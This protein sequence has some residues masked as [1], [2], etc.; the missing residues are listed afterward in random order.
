MLKTRE[1]HQLKSRSQRSFELT[2]QWNLQEVVS[3]LLHES[4][5]LRE[6]GQGPAIVEVAL[7]HWGMEVVVNKVGGC[8]HTQIPAKCLEQQKL[9]FDQIPLVE[10]NV[11]AAH[12]AQRIQLLQFGD[13]VLLLLK[14]TCK[15]T[16]RVVLKLYFPL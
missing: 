4:L 1:T 6:G 2:L 16:V 9:H 12:E 10:N 5:G 14:F 3:V 7:L 8:G 11:Q 13:P 15:E